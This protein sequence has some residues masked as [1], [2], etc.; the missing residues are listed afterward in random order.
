MTALFETEKSTRDIPFPQKWMGA[1]SSMGMPFL[2]T[3][4]TDNEDSFYP[5]T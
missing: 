3:D 1:C 2:V 4:V 5:Y